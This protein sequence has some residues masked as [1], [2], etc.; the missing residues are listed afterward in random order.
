MNRKI[1]LQL[2]TT[3]I[4]HL[5]TLKAKVHHFS[6]AQYFLHSQLNM[7][8]LLYVSHLKVHFPQK[9]KHCSSVEQHWLTKRQEFG[10]GATCFLIKK[11]WRKSTGN[12][13]LF[14]CGQGCPN[15]LLVGR[16]PAKYNPNLPQ[17][18]CLE[19]SN[20]PIKTLIRWFR[21]V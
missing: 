4:R 21:C 5:N 13:F 20:M 12:P 2:K 17:H 10:D 18:T 6:D 1:T 7:W 9:C 8:K 3:L 16:F 14:S 11:R 19:V 15:L